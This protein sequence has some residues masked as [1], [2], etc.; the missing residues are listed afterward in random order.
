VVPA[1]AARV[2]AGENS[3][4]FSSVVAGPEPGNETGEDGPTIC[5]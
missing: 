5:T 2:G 4:R 1:D 3:R